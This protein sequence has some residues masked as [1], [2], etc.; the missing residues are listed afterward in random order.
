MF[1]EE[2][3]QGHQDLFG[4]ELVWRQAPQGALGVLGRIEMETGAAW[5]PWA[6]GAGLA[7]HHGAWGVIGMAAQGL[8][9]DW[10]GCT[11]PGESVV[12]VSGLWR[13]AGWRA[14]HH[15]AVAWRAVEERRHAYN[16]FNMDGAEHRRLK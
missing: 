2:A 1:L 8:G 9:R 11:G 15:L 13:L 14:V 7:W 10:S 5:A 4:L 16:C 12:V 3:P 6:P